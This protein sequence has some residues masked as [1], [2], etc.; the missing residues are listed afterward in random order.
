MRKT[1]ATVMA[2]L[3]LGLS[4]WTFVNE[5]RIEAWLPGQVAEQAT[6]AQNQLPLQDNETWLVVVVD[7]AEHRADN[8]WGPDEATTMLDQAVVPYIDQLSGGQTN[9]TIVVHDTVIRATQPLAS[10]GSDGSGK[11]TATD[12]TFL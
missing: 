9:L 6:T 10:Y 12:G 1:A 7:F 2:L 8:G 3:F 11:D 5:D 4:A